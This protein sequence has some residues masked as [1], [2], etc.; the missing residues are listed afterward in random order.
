M[1]KPMPLMRSKLFVPGARPELFAKALAGAADALSLDLED[2]VPEAGKHDARLR[3]GEFVQSESARD[4]RKQIIVRINA[5]DSAHFK[6]DVASVVVPGV[7]LINLPKCESADEVLMAIAAIER[8]ETIFGTIEPI[9]VLANIETPK[10]LRGAAQIAAAH[11]RVA[12]L[13]LGLG[14]LFEPL[15]IERGDPATVHAALFALRMAAGESGVF[16]CDSAFADVSDADGFRAE[17][18]MAQRLGFIGKSCIHPSQ[19]PIANAVFRVTAAEI[20]AAQ[21]IVAAAR[22]A[23]AQGRG[24]FLVD[25][26]MI[27]PPFLQRAESILQA[28][29]GDPVL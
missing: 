20:E 3:V 10:G 16:C 7:A 22:A 1:T 18:Q 11:P 13:Q 15:G 27:D 21:R 19:V 17:A 29:Q 23:T 24:A 28:A 26:R 4:S 14:D 2:S 25:G 6:A 12:G 5:I 8:A 9:R